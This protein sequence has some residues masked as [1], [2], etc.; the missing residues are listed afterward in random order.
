MS[1][2]I[3]ASVGDA[4]TLDLVDVLAERAEI[5]RASARKA[6]ELGVPAILAALTEGVLRADGVARMTQALQK[7]PA[8]WGQ[9]QQG[10]AG[11]TAFLLGD[12]RAGAL[13]SAIGRFVGA[14]ASSSLIFLDDLTVAILDALGQVGGDVKADGKVIAK[15][16]K[17][18]SEDIAAAVPLG[19]A[20][21]LGANGSSERAGSVLPAATRARDGSSLARAR[22]ASRAAWVLALLVLTGLAWYLLAVGMQQQSDGEPGD[23]VLSA[24]PDARPLGQVGIRAEVVTATAQLHRPDL[25]GSAGDTARSVTDL[26]GGTERRIATGLVRLGRLFGLHERGVPVLAADV[27]PSPDQRRAEACR[28]LGGAKAAGSG[29]SAPDLARQNLSFASEGLRE[30]ICNSRPIANEHSAGSGAATQ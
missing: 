30:A 5:D 10:A 24:V 21:L 19:L 14:R 20:A 2:K 22:G 12:Q 23:R 7:G 16:L 18:Q 8:A 9:T 15:L 26:L 17:A 28:S 29:P 3:L 1:G 4:V 27:A 11:V 6:A 13:A 25:F